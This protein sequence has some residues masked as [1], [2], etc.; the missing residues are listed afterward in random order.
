[1]MRVVL[2][3]LMLPSLASAQYDS[4]KRRPD[5]IRFADGILNTYTS[6][7]RW[8]GKDWLKFGAITGSTALLTLADQPV[9]N[10]WLQRDGRILDGINEFGYHYGKP[11][12]AFFI[13]GGLYTAG[14]LF[15]NEWAPKQDL[16]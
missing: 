13:S 8:K 6:P 5:V 1:M 14:L 12:S 15:K 4:V 7:L 10:F 2:V 9:R 11:Y 16:P 3:L